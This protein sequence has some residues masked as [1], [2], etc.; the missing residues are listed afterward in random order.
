MLKKTNITRG[1]PGPNVSGEPFRVGGL[2]TTG[3][4]VVGGVQ[5]NTSYRLTSPADAEA[6]LLNSAYDLTSSNN[7][8]V[9]RHIVDYYDEAP[10]GTA[11][12]LRLAPQATTL[13]NL[14]D[15]ANIEFA[16]KLI[17]DA[18]GEIYNLAIGFNPASGYSETLTDG[19]N[20]DVR[21]AISKCEALYAWSVDNMREVYIALEG[22]GLGTNAASCADLRALPASPSGLQRN[23]HVTLVVGQDWDFAETLTGHARKYAGVG[24][25]IGTIGACNL[26]Q[27]P[28]E[29]ASFNLTREKNSRWVTAGL[30]NHVKNKDQEAMLATLDTKSYVFADT[31]PETTGYR[32]NGDHTCTPIVVDS[33]DNMNEHKGTYCRVMN[34]TT[35]RLRAQLTQEVRTTISANPATGKMTVGVQKYLTGKGNDVF[36]DLV[37][38]GYISGGETYVDG[39]SDIFVAQQVNY[40]FDVVPLGTIAKIQGK[41]NLKTSI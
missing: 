15:D 8:V 20:A 29:V 6:L 1:V 37:A 34:Y 16:R 40:S 30:S 10:E 33:N 32:W 35:R 28:G 21:A 24:K 38:S 2:I 11:F 31:H 17:V 25:Y 26:A 22:R 41:I 5:L 4:A 18:N 12:W 13:A 7:M 14:I 39:N 27:D 19:I 3:I 23:E 9:Y 36:D